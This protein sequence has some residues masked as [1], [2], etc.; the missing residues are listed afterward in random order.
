ML[1]KREGANVDNPPLVQEIRVEGSPLNQ[2]YML[3]DR[4]KKNNSFLPHMNKHSLSAGEAH[5]VWDP[6]GFE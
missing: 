2:A 1:P 6:G 5:K 3:W 4:G